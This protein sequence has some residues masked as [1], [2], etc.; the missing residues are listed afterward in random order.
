MKIAM[1]GALPALRSIMDRVAEQLPNHHEVTF[2][3]DQPENDEQRESFARAEVI[4]GLASHGGWPHPASLRMWQVPAAGCDRVDT[5]GF[6]G[7]A[8]LCNCFG[9]EIP[10]AEYIMASVL[11]WQ[12]PLVDAF[13]RMGNNDWYY[14]TPPSFGEQREAY[15]KTLG[16][17]GLGTIGRATAKRAK[18]FG[19]KVLAC[20]RKVVEV[21]GD[22][23]EYFPLD[24]VG[25]FAAQVDFLAISLALVEATANII[26]AALLAGMKKDAVLINVGRAG[27]IDEAD[28]FKALREGRI[29][30]AVLD[31]QYNYPTPD[32]PSAKPTNLDFTALDNAFLTSHMSG[33]SDKLV[34][35][36]AK[37]V[38]ENI[39]RLDEGATP[40]N[41]VWQAP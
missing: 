9:H 11:Y 34:S 33:A 32:N 5:N 30:G 41:I 12:L 20:N 28:F 29:R 21:G 1:F 36:R 17:L 2:L 6:P 22:V 38:A 40:E 37:F 24:R 26:D 13:E 16:I 27:L 18:A 23:D 19:M 4:V 25:E 31:P 14:Y 3:S 7:G 10:I 15:G 35:R 8:V 39:T